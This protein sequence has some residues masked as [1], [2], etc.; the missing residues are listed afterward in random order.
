MLSLVDSMQ[1]VK[2]TRD[3]EFSDREPGRLSPF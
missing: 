1:T 2:V 3:E